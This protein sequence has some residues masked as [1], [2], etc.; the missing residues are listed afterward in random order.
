M[1]NC[2]FCKIIN[3][4]VPTNFL[5]EDELVIAFKD[6]RPLAPVHVLVIPKRHIESVKDLKDGD[7]K[8]AG[9]IVMVAKKMAE[10]LRIADSGYKL[11]WRVGDDGGQEVPHIHVHLLGGAK[12][13]ENIRPV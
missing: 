5:Y 9:R 2:I 4:D 10:Q 11:L 3:K 7:E 1:T 8:L 13:S 12:L 6:I